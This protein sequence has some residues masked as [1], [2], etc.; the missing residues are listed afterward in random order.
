MGSKPFTMHIDISDARAHLEELRKK[1][2]EAFQKAMERAAIQFLT[3]ANNGS[4][5]SF[6]KPPIRYGV[7]R[8]SS[9]AFLGSRFL[10]A[11][12]QNVD[13]GSDEH[14]TPAHTG[15]GE[16]NP[17]TATFVWNTEYAA[18]MHEGFY[19]PGPVTKNDPGAGRKWLENH[20]KA[21]GEDFYAFVASEA[22][23]EMGTK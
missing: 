5:R 8:A 19:K 14:A 9:S 10:G 17:F 23:Q 3:W 22:A 15:S 12:P 4:A 13:S 7:L 16:K 1:S 2:P 6:S 18:R 20:L 21:D 11:F